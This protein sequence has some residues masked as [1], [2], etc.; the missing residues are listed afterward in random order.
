MK[1]KCTTPE[2]NAGISCRNYCC[3]SLYPRARLAEEIRKTEQRRKQVFDPHL[4]ATL[5]AD[6]ELGWFIKSELGVNVSSGVRAC[7]MFVQVAICIIPTKQS[8]TE[9]CDMPLHP[10]AAILSNVE[11]QLCSICI[12][13]Y[14]E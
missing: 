1:G 14:K 5:E 9:L 11:T 2:K 6:E 13:I 4:F 8:T 3:T 12:C 10:T 7:H